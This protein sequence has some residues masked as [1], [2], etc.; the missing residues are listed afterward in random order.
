MKGKQWLALLL[1]A[2][3]LLGLGACGSEEEAPEA[4]QSGGGEQPS[5]LEG[6]A[7]VCLLE[8]DLPDN[9]LK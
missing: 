7:N 9:Y 2:L 8:N 4:G 5:Y 3:L 6:S 1:A